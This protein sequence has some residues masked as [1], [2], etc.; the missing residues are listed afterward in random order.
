[1]QTQ[2]PYTRFNQYTL[3]DRKVNNT[4]R[5]ELGDLHSP[6]S[7]LKHYFGLP[8]EGRIPAM[9]LVRLRLALFLITV[10]TKRDIRFPT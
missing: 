7:K 9:A 1:M 3:D 2:I 4:E 8:G 6:S 10:Q 5:F